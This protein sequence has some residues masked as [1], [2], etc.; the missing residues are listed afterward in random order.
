METVHLKAS[1]CPN[2]G[3][4]LDACSGLDR[5]PGPGDLT[6]CIECSA[7]VR[8]DDD[9]QLTGFSEDEADR[10]LADPEWVAAIRRAVGVVRLYRQ[11]N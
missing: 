1:R 11:R 8:F 6:V 5:G 2:C 9:M 10:L 4:K 3:K 7:L